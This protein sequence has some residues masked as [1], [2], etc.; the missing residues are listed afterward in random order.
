[1]V[2]HMRLQEERLAD[3]LKQLKECNALVDA[4]GALLSTFSLPIVPF[5][6]GG[7]ATAASG[8]IVTDVVC[9]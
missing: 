4:F 5:S 2:R 1:M 8:V 3:F 7:T 9:W 6:C